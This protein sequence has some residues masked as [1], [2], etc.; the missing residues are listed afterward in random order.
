MLHKDNCV[1]THLTI[2]ASLGTTSHQQT[3]H[4]FYVHLRI[5]LYTHK[6]QMW[7]W[8]VFKHPSM[9]FAGSFLEYPL[10]HKCYHLWLYRVK[11]LLHLTQRYLL[12]HIAALWALRQELS[13]TDIWE[14]F[15]W[16]CRELNLE[17]SA[18]SALCS[19][20]SCKHRA[21]SLCGNHSPVGWDS[22]LDL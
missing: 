5:R 12:R 22:E 13:S 15:G 9:V 19:Y 8:Q 16:I 10:K 3:L 11:A 14:F 6:T 21:A 2:L 4:F 18:C 7:L 1:H 17:P 20:L